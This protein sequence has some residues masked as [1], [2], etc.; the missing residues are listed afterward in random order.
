MDEV[1]ERK[2]IMVSRSFREKITDYEHLRGLVA[3]YVARAAEKLRS[4]E[5]VARCIMVFLH[6]S[7]HSDEPYYGS[8]ATVKLGQYTADTSLLIK[9]ATGELERIFKKGHRYMK[10]GVMLADLMPQSR[11]PMTLF[12]DS[13]YSPRLKRRMAVMD[14]VNNKYGPQT[15]RLCAESRERWYMNQNYLSPS[16]TTRWSQLAVVR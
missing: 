3:G 16:Y 8:S 13:E 11:Q 4:Q 5:S 1:A 6:T 15:L 7:P 2:Q 10:A 9:A 12:A 14:F